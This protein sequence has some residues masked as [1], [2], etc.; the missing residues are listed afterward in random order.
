MKSHII[1]VCKLSDIA[2]AITIPERVQNAECGVRNKE[3]F[4][5]LILHSAFRIPHSHTMLQT[6]YT[7]LYPNRQAV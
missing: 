7:E 5:S 2:F 6:C 1:E 3:K 4:Q